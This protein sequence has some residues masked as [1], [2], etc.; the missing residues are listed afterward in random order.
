MESNHT[1]AIHCTLAERGVPKSEI[2]GTLKDLGTD[3]VIDAGGGSHPEEMVVYVRATCVEEVKV[4]LM[5]FGWKAGEQRAA[6]W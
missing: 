2:A 4:L 3:K 1:I 5:A 6:G